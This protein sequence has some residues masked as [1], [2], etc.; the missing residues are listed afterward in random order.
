MEMKI[1]KSTFYPSVIT[2]CSQWRK[3]FALKF[4][5]MGTFD[6]TQTKLKLIIPFLE[7]SFL[8]LFVTYQK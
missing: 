3:N 6:K 1:I 8:A 5:F 4:S 7:N 2:E